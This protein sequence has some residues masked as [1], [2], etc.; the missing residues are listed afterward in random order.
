MDAGWDA[1][2]PSQGYSSIKFAG[3]HLYSWVERGTVK[4]YHMFVTKTWKSNPSSIVAY[5][6]VT[7][8]LALLMSLIYD[9]NL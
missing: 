2:S 8:I 1:A 6:G 9:L 7:E 3:T 4:V 5:R